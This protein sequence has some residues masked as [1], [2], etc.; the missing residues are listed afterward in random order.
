MAYDRKNH[1]HESI[2]SLRPLVFSSM[3]LNR[4]SI[5]RLVGNKGGVVAAVE[6][7]GMVS[8]AAP[9]DRFDVADK[10][11][12]ALR[13][14]LAFFAGKAEGAAFSFTTEAGITAT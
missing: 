6:F 4:S 3:A 2:Y 5:S 7:V 10:F 11:T 8:I 13:S 1:K 12:P 14:P 9:T